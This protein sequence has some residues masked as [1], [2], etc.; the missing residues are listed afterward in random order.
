MTEFYAGIYLFVH[1]LT[2]IN[3]RKYLFINFVC[4]CVESVSFTVSLSRASAFNL[5]SFAEISYWRV[6]NKKKKHLMRKSIL[7]YLINL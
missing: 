1:L 5:Y 2:R 6:Q 7:I 3:Q 4:V